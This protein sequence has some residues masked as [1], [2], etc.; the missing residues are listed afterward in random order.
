[1][2]DLSTIRISLEAENII[3]AMKEKFYFQNSVDAM[4][5]ALAY[6]L[7][8][9]RNEI[10]FETLDKTYDS[11]GTNLNIGTFDTENRLIQQVILALYPNCETPYRYARVAINYGALKIGKKMKESDSFKISDLLQ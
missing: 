11:L 9:D 5:F 10:D 3:E 2:K 6:A 8:E 7:K 1:M 4:R